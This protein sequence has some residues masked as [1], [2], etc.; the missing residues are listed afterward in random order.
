MAEKLTGR[1]PHEPDDKT[2]RTVEQLAAVGTP[3]VAIGKILGI[4][5]NTL[6]KY[7]ADELELGLHKANAQMANTLFKKGMEGDTACMIFWLKT[8]GGF[9][10]TVKVANVDEDGK[11]KRVPT[12]QDF[13]DMV[14]YAQGNRSEEA[15]GGKK[16]AE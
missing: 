9:T 5:D 8:R 3:Q 14:S 16:S 11:P 7:Y 4:S 10:E 2:R 12:L 15:S 6:R 1:P 13:V